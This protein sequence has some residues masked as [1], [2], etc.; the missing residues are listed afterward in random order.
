MITQLHI[1]SIAPVSNDATRNPPLPM[2]NTLRSSSLRYSRFSFQ[3]RRSLATGVGAVPQT[4]SQTR[5]P[6]PQFS[7]ATPVDV[8]GP[9][10]ATRKDVYQLPVN[11]EELARLN[12]QHVLLKMLIGGN[13]TDRIK[14]HLADQPGQ[15]KVIL[16]LGCGTGAW[17]M[18]MATDF[19]HCSV[20]GA[21][22]APM[23]LGLAPKN[24]RIDVC[25][26]N[27]GLTMYQNG[28]FNLV[29]GRLIAMG[30]SA[31]IKNYPAL[32]G[33][34]ARILRPGGFLQLQ[35]WDFFVV[36]AEKNMIGTDSWFARWCASLRHGLAVRSASVNAAESLDATIRG[37]GTLESVQQQNVWMPI[38]PCFPKDTVDGLRLNLVGE[39]MRENVK[40]FIKGGRTLI[41]GSGMSVE[42]YDNLALQ[43]TKEVQDVSLPMYLRLNCVTAR[44]Q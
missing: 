7:S 41:V 13:Y 5:T 42:D 29:N 27:K 20:V 38:G 31:W 10:P 12:N 22:V 21:D 24:L 15:K 11:N 2:F 17:A 28:S 16:D 30:K 34:V 14:E 1:D 39:F 36:D 9:P 19:P 25:D 6:A 8:P 44:K 23:D 37:Q 35:E 3:L 33:E 18:D 4:I 43:A 26:A 32:I 40:A